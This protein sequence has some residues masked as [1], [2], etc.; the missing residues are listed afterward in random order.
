MLY[1]CLDLGI[2]QQLLGAEENT[3]QTEES[4]AA[5]TGESLWRSSYQRARG[6]Y[7]EQGKISTTQ[8]CS[9]IL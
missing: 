9:T 4:E 2:L 3:A 1:F 5:F 6:E 7:R 8:V